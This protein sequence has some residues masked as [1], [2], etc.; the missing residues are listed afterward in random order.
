[1]V[2]S[3]LGQLTSEVQRLNPWWREPVNWAAR[4][5]DLRAAATSGLDYQ[6]SALA[7]LEPGG[8]YLLRGPR[9]VGK[10]VTVKQVI[11]RLLAAGTPPLSVVRLAVDGWVAKNLRTVVQNVPL[12]PLP[13]GASRW[14]FIDEVTA[15]NGDWATEVKWLRD[16]VVEFAEATVVLTG[17]S[18]HALT[19]GAGTLAG[20]RGRRGRVERADR[21]LM[22]MGFR[23]FA[24]VWHPGVRSLPVLAIADL[25]T[26]AAREA[27]LAASMWSADL[28]PLWE[29]YLHYGGFP[30]AV[31]AAKA[32]QPVPRWFLDT[33]FD[34]VYRDAF[35]SSQLDEPQTA[36]LVAR[37]WESLA[38]PLSMTGVGSEVGMHH[39]VV[40]RHLE[41]LRDAYLA[42]PV[43]QLERE[44]LPNMRA[45]A[46]IYPVDPLLA[47][48]AHLRSAS[49]PDPD[50]TVLAEAQL[51]MALQRAHLATGADWAGERPLFYLRTPNRKEVDFVGEAL[52]GA[53]LEGKYTEGGRWLREAATVNTTAYRGILATRNV[54]DVEPDSGIAWAVPACVLAVLVDVEA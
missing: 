22:P 36:A 12:P 15:V 19:Q 42:W 53:A 1:M 27:Y 2:A 14:W 51:G 31:A 38:T 25:H 52:G 6:P 47:R 37:V 24:A 48:M 32:G 4:D 17:S 26:P 28:V 44:W 8:L 41:Y 40:G 13:E 29:T 3:S 18:S 21:T 46:K 30:A 33:L 50:L 20:R 34:V 43:E 23:E 16:N 5:V 35:A 39:T 10:T 11:Q 45:Q 7:G 9:R 49:R 54:L